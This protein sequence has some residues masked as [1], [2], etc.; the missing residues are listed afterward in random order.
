MVL[1]PFRLSTYK[2]LLPIFHSDNIM[3]VHIVRICVCTCTSV[4]Q[5]VEMLIATK[6]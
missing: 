2:T 6:W 5:S 4:F 1:C 3:H